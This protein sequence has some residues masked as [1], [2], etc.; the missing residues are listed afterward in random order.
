MTP[1]EDD[2]EFQEEEYS[3]E[4]TDS[5]EEPESDADVEEHE[6]AEPEQGYSTRV[7]PNQNIRLET[8]EISGR[9]ASKNYS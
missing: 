4:S 3:E 2:E 8:G 1:S 5:S 9:A 7:F 6:E